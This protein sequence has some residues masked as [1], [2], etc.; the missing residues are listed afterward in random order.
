MEKFEMTSANIIRTLI[1]NDD[2][3]AYAISF[4]YSKSGGER[5]GEKAQIK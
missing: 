1:C 2:T 5:Q 4:C 3:D